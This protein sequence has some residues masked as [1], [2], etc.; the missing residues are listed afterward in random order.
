MRTK[1]RHLFLEELYLRRFGFLIWFL[2][3]AG[4]VA[5]FAS[6]GKIMVNNKDLT[7]FFDQYPQQ[8]MDAF[9]FDAELLTTYEGWMAT[10]PYMFFA[11]LLCIYAAMLA[12][13]TVAREVDQK[14]GEFLFSL[15]AERRRIY[16]AKA[17]SHLVQY[18]LVG[19]ASVLLAA[20]IG[21]AVM[22]L[23]NASGLVL[24]YLAAYLAAL[25]SAGIG[26]AITSFVDSERI[27]LSG[28]IG[29][30]VLSFLLNSFANLDKSIR[31][32]AK[33]SIFHAFD[34]GTIL[35]ERTLPAGGVLLML[36]ICLGG[37]F[38]GREALARKDLTF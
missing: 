35:A 27:A 21:E 16:D 3:I 26:Y 17:A 2:V 25:A 28:S 36:A 32:L 24:N 12:S 4:F 18:T 23:E 37:F 34:P 30:V 7:E 33:L 5:I 31:W 11:L 20:L 19:A 38:L 15:P 1:F 10:E 29:F 8:L 22:G 13:S 9:N 6:Y 14:T